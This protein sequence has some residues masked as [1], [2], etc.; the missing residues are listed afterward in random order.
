MNLTA[1]K[2]NSG[3]GKAEGLTFAQAQPRAQDHGNA[4]ARRDRIE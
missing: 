3:N 1:Q 4:V 2:V